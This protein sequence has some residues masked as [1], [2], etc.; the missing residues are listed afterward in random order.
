MTLF[1]FLLF[2][3]LAS[4]SD[5]KIATFDGANGTTFPWKFEGDNVMG[6][7]SIGTFK[8]EYNVGVLNGTVNNVPFLKAPG[9][10][11]AYSVGELGDLSAY[12]NGTL[13]MRV[14]SATPYTGWKMGFAASDVPNPAPYGTGSFKANVESL[15]SEWQVVGVPFTSFSWDW[16]RYTGECTTTDPDGT[17]H[18]CCNKNHTEV[19]PTAKFLSTINSVQIWAEAALGDVHLEIDWV[20]VTS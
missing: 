9:K 19:C 20:G 12:L 8:V 7:A 6:G 15:G 11:F 4:G 16:S 3:S 1:L 2:V 13:Q 10:I 14:K 5:H 17:V 18:H